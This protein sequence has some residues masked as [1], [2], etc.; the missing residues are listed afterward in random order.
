M[1]ILHYIEL[2]GGVKIMLTSVQ[3]A[4]FQ[5]LSLI[6]G[7][8]GCYLATLIISS[9]RSQQNSNSFFTKHKKTGYTLSVIFAL[10][11]VMSILI[12]TS[13][14]E[15]ANVLGTV[16]TCSSMLV[17]LTILQSIKTQSSEKYFFAK[18]KKLG[19]LLFVLFGLVP[20]YIYT[21]LTDSTKLK[22]TLISSICMLLFVHL[23]CI[24]FVP[25]EKVKKTVK[26]N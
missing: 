11:P 7:L 8:L 23:M 18:H 25:K 3:L 1:C 19:Y 4:L 16:V 22:V 24:C 20:N 2:K 5:G 12:F 15:D 14:S 6:G 13:L 10:S 17:A 26:I 9:I 21:V